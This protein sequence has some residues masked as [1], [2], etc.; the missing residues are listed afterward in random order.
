MSASHKTW[1]AAAA[2]LLGVSGFTVQADERI[3]LGTPASE[4][5]IAGWDIDV[6]PDGQGLPA[7]SGDALTGEE[8]YLERCAVCHGEFGEAVGRYP[9][10]I[11]GEDTLESEDPIKTIGSYWPYATTIWDYV[12]RAMPF[13]DAQSLTP[14]ETYAITAFLLYQNDIVEDDQVLDQDN[15][16]AV[17]MP[18]RQGF[19]LPDPRPDVAQAEPCMKDCRPEAEVI[20]R[21]KRLDVTPETESQ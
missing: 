16:A 12:Y 17:E 14:D 11:G 9:V 8:I 18:N 21:A 15:L 3:G 5:E 19:F 20:G 7:G 4:A 13:G 2:L 6:R 10:L 1:A